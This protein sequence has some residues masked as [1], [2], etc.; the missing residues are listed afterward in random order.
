RCCRA[1][2]N[3]S[4]METGIMQPTPPLPS[5]RKVLS[6]RRLALLA[7]VAALGAAVLFGGPGVP[8]TMPFAPASASA[9]VSAEHAARPVRLA[10]IVERVKPA[11]IGVRVKS[12]A[13]VSQR[14]PMQFNGEELPQGLDQFLRRFGFP[15]MPNAPRGRQF[16]MAQGSGFFISPDGYA[17]T[18][19]HVVERGKSIEIQADDG[20]TYSAKVVG[21]D[22]KTDLAL[23]KIDGRSDFP[24][25]K[26]ADKQPRIG[27][28]VIAVGNLLGWGGTVTA[29]IVSA[30]GR[31]IGARPYDDFIQI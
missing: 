4:P 17:V 31:D 30:R 13:T 1:P 2:R 19:N 14:E 22:P 3:F 5:A 15:N 8:N 10:A 29:G 23:L 28:G 12:D 9:Q 25:V 18:N 20:K 6:A 21:T 11:V 27:D 7:S 26:L 16:S 24:F